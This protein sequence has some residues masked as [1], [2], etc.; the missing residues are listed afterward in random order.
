MSHFRITYDGP[1]LATHQMDVHELAPALLAMGDLLEAATR[2]LNGDRVKPQVNVRASFKTG[3]FGIDFELATVWLLKV[4][5]L[6][7]SDD[8]TSTAN[9]LAILGALGLVARKTGVSLIG[10]LKWLRGRTLTRVEQGEDTVRLSVDEDALEIEHEVLALLREL[11]VREALDK[12]LAPLDRDGVDTFATGTEDAVAE[13]VL[14][15]EREWFRTPAI[16]DAM[17]LDDNRRMAF[18]IVSLAFREDNKWRLYDGAATI[19]ATITDTR[20]LARVDQNLEIFAKGD[21]LICRVRVR[22]WQTTRGVRTE[23]EVT[24]VLEHRQAGRKLPLP[25]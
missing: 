11:A 5:D 20:F 13:R 18:S 17:I 3:S 1:A 7:G 2:V 12:L 6:F 22:Q 24:E 19:H 25:L 9:A 14:Q 4:R 15:A 16:E 10:A 8:A 21:A 23:Y